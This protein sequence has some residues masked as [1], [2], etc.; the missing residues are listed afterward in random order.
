L[1]DC[2]ATYYEYRRRVTAA[3]YDETLACLRS[4]SARQPEAASVWSLLA[5]LYIDEYASSFG[6]TG[7]AALASARDATA[8]ALAIDRDDFTANLALTRVR[9]FDGDRRFS[10][11][12]ERA[13][14]LR[15]NSAQAY[16]QGGFLLVT[17]GAAPDQGLAM[18]EKARELSHGPLGFYHL[19]Y[20]AG[21]LRERRFDD[22]L[23][24]AL[25]VEGPTWVFAQAVLAAAAAHCGRH[26]VARAAAQRIRELYPQF[27]AEALANFERWHFDAE[28]YDALVSGLQAAGLEL[29][30]Q[31]RNASGG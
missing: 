4:V 21:Y 22:A 18:T 30:P 12:I 1:R 14:A 15:P 29:E 11:S 5:M 19:T 31:H 3:G 25:K 9:F 20:A 2:L 23:A 26:D 17:T 10:E 6:R 24:S 13:V 27:E 16:A 7:D 28:L 8:K